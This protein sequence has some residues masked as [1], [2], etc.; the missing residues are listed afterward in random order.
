MDEKYLSNEEITKNLQKID[1]N[2]KDNAI[3]GDLHN[4]TTG[5]DGTQT[6]LRFL[7]RS[8]NRGKNIVSISD[9]DSVK[10]YEILENQIKD[11]IEN[12]QETLKRN[13]ITKEEKEK[14][15]KG[16]ER[17][18]NVLSDVKV[19]PAIECIT[20]YDGHVIEILGYG[21]N[22]EMMKEELPK[23]KEGLVPGVKVLLEGTDRIIKDNNLPFDRFVIENRN[24]FK[25]LFYHELIKHPENAALYE[26]IEGETEE[27]KAENFSKKYLENSESELY[28]DMEK[29]EKRDTKAIRADFLNMLKTNE[30]NITFD[31]NIIAYSHAIAGEFYNELRKHPECV[32][33]LSED[34]KSDFKKFIYQELYNPESPFFIDMTPSRPSRQAT[35]EAIHKCRRKSISCTSRKI[36]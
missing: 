35:I 23:L 9:H 28:V 8:H 31:E 10:G 6:P 12:L 3:E 15:T 24:D 27:E 14:A 19:L 33:L 22:P 1:N 13:D 18:L 5:S 25:K 4:H 34:T 36:F 21:V 26:S 30:E 2:Q 7:L 16:A 29:T 11:I 32:E 17:L 20:S